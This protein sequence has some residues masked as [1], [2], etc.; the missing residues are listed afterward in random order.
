M[1]Q[2]LDSMNVLFAAGAL[3]LALVVV[4]LVLSRMYHRASKE[5]SFVRTGLGGQRVIMNGG[6]LVLPVLHETIPVNMNTLRL[7]VR[8][9][10][11]QALITR[12]R[13]RVDVAVEFYVRVQPTDDA[14]ANAAQTLGRRTMNPEA[15]KDL[16]EGKFVDSLRSVA[17][18]M[19]MEELHEQ[20]VKFVQKVQATVSEDLLKNGLELEAASLTGL[21]QTKLEFLN[22]QNAF[23]AEGLTRLTEQI[24]TRRKQRNEIEQDTQ[25]AIQRKNLESEREK[26]NLSR[27]SEYARLEQQRELEV[28]RAEQAAEIAREQAAKER[29]S[30]QAQ[31]EAKQQVDKTDIEAG[32]AIDQQKIE[33]Q[34]A[35]KEQQIAMQRT[36]EA[37]EIERRKTIEL[38]EQER[39]IAIAEKSRAQ[40]EA[41]AL[42]DQARALAVQAEEAVHTVREREKAERAKIIELVKAAEEAERDAIGLTVAAQAEKKAAEDRAAAVRTVAAAEAE[43]ARLA[44]QG[45]ADAEKLRADASERRYAVEAEGKRQIHQA[46]NLLSAAQVAMQVRLAIVHALPGIIRESVKPMERIDGIKIMQVAG[47]GGTDGAAPSNGG[48]LGVGSAGNLADQVVSSALRYRAQAPL[49]DALLSELGLSGAEPGKLA[50]GALRL[51]GA[52]PASGPSDGVPGAAA[53]SPPSAS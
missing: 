44:A 46:D 52:P 33:V 36:V 24:E 35:V 40:S 51:D 41:Q 34:R 47:I 21:D 27:E 29:E 30:R 53:A 39:A 16:I 20:R 45:D 42:A 49:V 6:A 32:R 13:M 14:I 18:E 4:G 37:A 43:R 2:I 23:D 11:E 1:S 8:R 19:A 50:A 26:L 12:D 22:P 10:N 25:V 5:V 31:I 3:L 38:A 7:E 9:A 15:L 28:R 48:G 17:A